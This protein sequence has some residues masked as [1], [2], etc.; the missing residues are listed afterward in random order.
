M[1]QKCGHLYSLCSIRQSSV[2]NFSQVAEPLRKLLRK[3][4]PFVWGTEQQLAFEEL[5]RLMTSANA[6]AYF[7]GDCKTRI[8]ADAG[9]DGLGAVLLQLHGGEWRAVSYASRNLTEV[10]KANYA[11]TEKEALALVW[12]CERFNLY[13]YG[14]EFELETDHK[15]LECIF[16]R[17]SKPSARIERWVLR[18]QCH[19]YRV[20]YCP[21]KT[22]IADALS[23]LN[24][25]NPK[26]PSSEKEDLVRFVAQGSTPVF[27][28]RERLKGSLRMIQN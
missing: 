1:C 18:L 4:Q 22:N 9:P 14:R 16:S 10:R 13:V 6:L 11:Q 17:T 26:D 20:V 25:T 28:T 23:R 27:L 15:P 19:N 5:K 21:G 2:P 12:A 8:V 3:G 24:Q 7:R